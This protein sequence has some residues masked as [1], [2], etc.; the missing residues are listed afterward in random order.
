MEKLYD[1]KN[2]L[3]MM[4]G[5]TEEIRELAFMLFDLGPQMID[6]IE[7]SIKARK[8]TEAGNTAHKL[9]S[10]LKLWGMETL[11]PLSIFIEEHGRKADDADEISSQ[12][13]A[14]KLGFHQV[15]EQMKLEFN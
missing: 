5:N 7:R 13:H 10:T 14:L 1:S 3:A 8:W 12:F 11:V 15:I 6:E 9:K 2:L 4:D